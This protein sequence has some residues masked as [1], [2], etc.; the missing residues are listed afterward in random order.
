MKTPGGNLK[1]Q[2]L[3]PGLKTRLWNAAGALVE[4]LRAF[5]ARIIFIERNEI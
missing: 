3:F 4:K 5:G 1:E 2:Q